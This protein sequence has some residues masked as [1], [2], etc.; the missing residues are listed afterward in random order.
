MNR[1][2]VFKLTE[3]NWYPP[4]YIDNNAAVMVSFT[5][6]RSEENQCEQWRVCVWGNDDCGMEKDFAFNEEAKAWCCFLE[7]IGMEYV[8]MKDLKKLGFYSA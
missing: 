4:Y 1:V 6:L 5:P 8:N 3:D 7:V 2:D